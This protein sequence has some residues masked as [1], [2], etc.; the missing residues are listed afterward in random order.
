MVPTLQAGDLVVVRRRPAYH[1]GDVVT[2]R[3]PSGL[4]RGHRIIHRIVGGNPTDGFTMRGD[5]KADE[6]L[7]RP[8]P[9]DIEGRLWKRVPAAGRAVA[10]GRSPGV[11]AAVAGGFAFAFTLTWKPRSRGVAGPSDRAEI[12][13][14]A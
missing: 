1:V 10:L 3:I 13:V 9:S 11:L 12:E 5:N 2:Y 4:F 6:D 8:N 14:P 7:W